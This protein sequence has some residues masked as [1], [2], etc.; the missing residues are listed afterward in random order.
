M[1]I[2]NEKKALLKGSEK[3]IK[4]IDCNTIDNKGPSNCD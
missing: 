3:P 2:I 4:L 1:A